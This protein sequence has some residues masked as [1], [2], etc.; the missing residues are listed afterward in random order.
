MAISRTSIVSIRESQAP[1]S[2]SCVWATSAYSRLVGLLAHTSLEGSNSM[3][4]E[5]C[6]QVH[7]FFMRF[8]I[9]VVFL[10][11][12]NRVLKILPMKPWRLSPLV[13]G[14]ERI[15]ELRFGQ[16]QAAGLREGSHL[17]FRDA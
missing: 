4:I 11:T 16:C 3:M 2:Q 14:A 17:E 12:D 6:K 10:G 5:P 1:L 15:L 13:W 9:D 7:T 8:P